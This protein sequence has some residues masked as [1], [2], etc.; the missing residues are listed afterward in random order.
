MASASSTFDAVVFD[1]ALH[2]RLPKDQLNIADTPIDYRRLGPPSECAA[3]R[4]LQTYAGIHPDSRRAC[5]RVV[6]PP[7][8]LISKLRGSPG[9]SDP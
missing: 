7:R 1:R 3:D 2:V 8:R 5:V 9:E 4:R 6:R